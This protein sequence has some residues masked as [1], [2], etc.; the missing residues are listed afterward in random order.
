MSNPVNSSFTVRFPLPGTEITIPQLTTLILELVNK[1]FGREDIKVDMI[2][3][4]ILALDGIKFNLHGNDIYIRFD[5]SLSKH[6]Q[7]YF[8][9]H[10]SVPN[11]AN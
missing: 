7:T 5:K 9:I 8:E 10:F 2:T 6:G 11:P 1:A 3:V 4:G